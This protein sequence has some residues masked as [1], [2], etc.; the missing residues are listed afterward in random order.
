VAGAFAR[1]EIIA[2][3]T[4]AAHLVAVGAIGDQADFDLY[5]RE[6]EGADVTLTRLRAGSRTEA[7]DPGRRCLPARGRAGSLRAVGRPGP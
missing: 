5:T 1:P 6:L 4:T 3:V 7:P 2:G